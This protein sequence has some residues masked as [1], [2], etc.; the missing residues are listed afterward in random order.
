MLRAL[1]AGAQGILV[2]IS[3]EPGTNRTN[4]PVCEKLRR[5]GRLTGPIGKAELHSG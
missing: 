2:Y 4:N 1:S 5:R 3:N